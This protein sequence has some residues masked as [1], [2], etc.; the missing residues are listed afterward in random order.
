MAACC[1]RKRSPNDAL[2]DPDDGRSYC[3]NCWQGWLSQNSERRQGTGAPSPAA[4][5]APPP[6]P[7][8]RPAAPETTFDD[9]AAG[10]LVA[11]VSGDGA[12]LL[13][14]PRLGLVFAAERLD[15]R[16]VRVGALSGCGGVVLDAA[17]GAAEAAPEAA[18]AA[19]PFAVNAADHCETP[20]AAYADIAPVL[21]W[22][23]A[24]VGKTDGELAIY[25]PYFCDGGVKRRLGALGFGNV[26]NA[27]EDFYAARDAGTVPEYDVLVTNPPYKPCGGVD[28]VEEVLGF[29]GGAGRPFFILQPNY[30]YTKAFYEG[31]VGRMGTRP[32]YL[33]PP[34]PRSYVYETP[35]GLRDVKGGQRKTSPFVTFWYGWVGEVQGK[36]VKDW[37]SGKVAGTRL[38]V[39]M[40]EYFLGDGFK[41]SADKTR[42]R[43]RGKKRLRDKG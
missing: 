9:D 5:G 27:R 18:E 14:S 36:F 22:L 1:P 20:A 11:A 33:T 16:L 28:H 13:T 15:G 32:F 31:A 10:E 34:L 3:G 42:K 25:D 26:Y 30:V 12:F 29:V 17:A 21:S 4:S 41:D 8:P 24:R 6:R 35:E 39:V 23:A 37:A 2:R 19:L 43:D 7:R 38:E 40:S